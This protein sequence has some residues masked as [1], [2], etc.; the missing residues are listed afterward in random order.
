MDVRAMK[1]KKISEMTAGDK[2]EFLEQT[3]KAMVRDYGVP[4]EFIEAKMIEDI[5][6][7]FDDEKFPKMDPDFRIDAAYARKEFGDKKPELIDYMLW[8]L[9]FVTKSEYVDW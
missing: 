4:W 5:D 9:K 1:H 6:N 8:S 2:A 7:T 3:K